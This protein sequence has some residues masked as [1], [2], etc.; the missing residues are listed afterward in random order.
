[1]VTCRTYCSAKA[2][3]K[4]SLDKEKIRE[5]WQKT[6]PSHPGARNDANVVG[7]YGDDCKYN[8]VG[9]KLIGISLN[10]ILFEQE[11]HLIIIYK[12]QWCFTRF[13]LNLKPPKNGT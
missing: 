6:D 3:K 1:M 9:E 4:L 7:L 5:Y 8:A 12:S 2:S 13:F 10:V 11:S